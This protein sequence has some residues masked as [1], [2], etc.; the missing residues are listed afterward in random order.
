[1]RK[2][3]TTDD[4]LTPRVLREYA[5][6]ADGERGALIGP[7]GSV[8]WLCAPRWDSP[9]VFSGLLGGAGRYTV[10]PADPLARVGRLLRGRDAD[11]A[12]PLGE[13]GWKT[14][15]RE[16][17]AMPADPHRAVLLRRVEALDG[18]AR[19]HRLPRPAGRLR[20]GPDA[21]TSSGTD[22]RAG[23]GAAARCASGGPG[24]AGPARPTAG[25]PSTRAAGRG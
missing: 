1:M 13:H 6:V 19:R 17:L 8:A 7:D 24:R 14:E 3:D 23:P 16:A 18:P 4:V 10:T 9:A 15:C 25:W 21:P 2:D 22:G 20:P 11:L 5:L 12:Q